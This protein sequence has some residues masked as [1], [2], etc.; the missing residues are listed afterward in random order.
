MYSREAFE[1]LAARVG[2]LD[3]FSPEARTMQRFFF[4]GAERVEPDRQGRIVIPLR[5]LEE[6]K[7][8]REL[9]IAGVYDHLEIWDRAAWREHS[10]R[11]KGA[12]RMLPSV[13]PTEA[14]H[15]PVLADEVLAA[16]APAPGDTIVDCTFGSGGHS[17]LLL[18]RLQGDGS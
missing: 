3:S 14:D 15:V 2:T 9:T 17:E 5:L 6:A 8:G 1:I 12:P 11:P 7:A 10:T 13:L 18:G 16:L 4:T